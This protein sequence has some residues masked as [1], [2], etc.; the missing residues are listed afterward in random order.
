MNNDMSFLEVRKISFTK[1]PIPIPADY[2]PIYKIAQILLI[3]KF[4]CRKEKSSLIKL[5]FFSWALKSEERVEKV[6]NLVHEKKLI[7]FSMWRFEPSLNR[8]LSFAI[9]EGFVEQDD[10]NYHLTLKGEDFVEEL[11]KFS[12]L[13]EKE[14]KFV[15]IVKKKVTESLIKDISRRWEI[16]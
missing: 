14:K 3:L 9:A 4:C 10:I 5:H 2:R 6:L 7:D 16:K 12:Q 15:N 1:K 8:A 13:M 11:M